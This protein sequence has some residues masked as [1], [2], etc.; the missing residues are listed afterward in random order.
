MYS[1][2]GVIVGIMSIIFLAWY[3]FVPKPIL[4]D[5]ATGYDFHRLG[6][7]KAMI[8][9]YH[10]NTPTHHWELLQTIDVDIDDKT[11]SFDIQ[12]AG[13]KNKVSVILNYITP[14]NRGDMVV[15][16][17]K[18][19]GQIE[20]GINGFDGVLV[21]KYMQELMTTTDEQIYL[22]YPINNDNQNSFDAIVS[23]DKPYDE[24]NMNL[25]NI[26]IS[27]TLQK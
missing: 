10:S 24:L 27:V 11:P 12:V 18:I 4:Y 16:H 15:Y 13:D 25:D 2:L 20:V 23:L 19:I 3:F 6:Y 1:I 21:G 9:V 26:L 17:S 22:V 14:E 5:D 7:T 8:K